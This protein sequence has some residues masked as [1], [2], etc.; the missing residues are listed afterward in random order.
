MAAMRGR[1]PSMPISSLHNIY[2]H[3]HGSRLGEGRIGPLTP[4]E[5]Q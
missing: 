3:T 1:T 5:Q 4:M 2:Y